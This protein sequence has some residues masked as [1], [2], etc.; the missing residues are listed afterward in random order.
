MTQ[1][2]PVITLDGPAAS[3]KGTIAEL[4]ADA[5]GFHYLDSGAL[6]RIATLAALKA[7]VDLEDAEGLTRI[8]QTIE[9]VFEK[10]EILLAGDV[11]TDAIRANDVSVAT[12]R[13]A[14]VPGVREA[15]F[16]LQRR[17]AKAPGLVADGRDMGTVVFPEAPLKIFMTADVEVRAK[18]RYD[19]LVKKGVKAELAQIEKELRER[20]Q[21]DQNRATA[22]LKAAPDAHLLDTTHMGI[23]DVVKNV[24][25]WWNAI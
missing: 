8:A 14:A 2:V 20:D 4:V 22:P 23:E 16:Q 13:V 5:L 17:F 21:R 10:G 18:R 24:L 19:Q 11:I 12:S 25:K 9:P 3:G 15:L 1:T 7:G 6:Y